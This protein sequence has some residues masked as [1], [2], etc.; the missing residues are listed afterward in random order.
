MKKIKLFFLQ[1]P[2]L[3]YKK[4]YCV[5]HE[6]HIKKLE[7]EKKFFIGYDTRKY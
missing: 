4:R 1:L 3:R 2:F 7:Y 6:K 5:V